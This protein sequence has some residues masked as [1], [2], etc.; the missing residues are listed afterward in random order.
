MIL[1]VLMLL[2]IALSMASSAS[3]NSFIIECD[4]K[5][6]GSGGIVT[7]KYFFARES[8]VADIMVFDSYVKTNN[9]DKPLSTRIISDINGIIK[10]SWKLRVKSTMQ[11]NLLIYYRAELNR[12]LS[13][14]RISGSLADYPAHRY[15]TGICVRLR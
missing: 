4:M 14:V 3:A 1:K 5:G 12:N 13:Q 8:K 15:H 9:N 6:G 2:G 10:V 7:S 11:E